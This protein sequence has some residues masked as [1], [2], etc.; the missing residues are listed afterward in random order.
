MLCE[1]L[2]QRKG[3]QT[4][5]VVFNAQKASVKLSGRPI[6]QRIVNKKLKIIDLFSGCGGFSYGFESAGFEVVLGVDNDTPALKTF[7]ENHKHAETCRQ[8]GTLSQRS[9]PIW[10]KH[11]G[12]EG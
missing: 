10:Q 2:A 6:K 1:R 12:S 9:R 7:K 5:A 4:L 3:Q 11:C 8:S